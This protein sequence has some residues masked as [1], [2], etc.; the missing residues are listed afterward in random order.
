[1]ILVDTDED[2]F[3]DLKKFLEMLYNKGVK[4]LMVEG[5]GTVIWNFLKSGFVDDFFIY[6]GPM[7]I[8]GVNTPTF[9][10]KVK[11]G[12]ENIKLRL[13]ETKKIGPGIILHYKLIK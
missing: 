12:E 2:G 7:I 9:S 3:I 13:V 1:M 10:G 11:V 4:K 8:G 5:G 6:V